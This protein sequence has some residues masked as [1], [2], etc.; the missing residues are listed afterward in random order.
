[1]ERVKEAGTP[2][3][4]GQGT[5]GQARER[6]RSMQQAVTYMCYEEEPLLPRWSASRRRTGQIRV[7]T[8]SPRSLVGRR[9][10]CGRKLP[11][12]SD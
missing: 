6:A 3:L 10:V 8:S 2:N 7:R 12:S 4:V 5:M 9:T 11:Q 1:M